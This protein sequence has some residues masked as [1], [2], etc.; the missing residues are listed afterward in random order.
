[1]NNFPFSEIYEKCAVFGMNIDSETDK[2]L[3][4][5]AEKLIE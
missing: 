4:I 3:R 5:Y 1:M 2:K